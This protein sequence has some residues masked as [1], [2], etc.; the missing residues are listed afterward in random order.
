MRLN[1]G[2][3]RL[4]RVTKDLAT[5][6]AVQTRRSVAIGNF[7]GVHRGHQALI[8]N[9]AEAAGPELTP[10][11]LTFDPH[12]RAFFKK[13]EPPFQLTLEPLKLQRLAALGVEETIILPFDAALAGT[14]AE[15][16]LDE[17]VFGALDA[18]LVATG[19]DFRFGKGRV[20]DSAMLAAAAEKRGARYVRVEQVGDDGPADDA[21][22]AAAPYSSSAVRKALRAGE[23]ERAAQILGDWHRIEGMVSKGDQRGRDLGFPTANLGLDG[24]LAPKFGVYAT[25]A[26]VMGGDHQGVYPAVSSL[27]VRPTF[28]E[29]KPNFETFLLDFKGDLY[30][31]PL[32]VALVTFLR[33]EIA[34]EG[35]EPLIAQMRQDVE[36]ARA[37]LARAEDAPR[38]WEEE[39]GAEQA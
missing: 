14:S 22:G 39:A 21:D 28:G 24:V 30:G 8:R 32:S 10:A 6:R 20:G 27:G 36:D 18:R 38:P 9:A 31:A 2:I 29:N 17:I 5:A 13:D 25:K 19:A 4:M 12:P 1:G 26:T 33:P 35:V 7:D 16:F 11:V 15:A 34:Y 23:P 37:A 3:G